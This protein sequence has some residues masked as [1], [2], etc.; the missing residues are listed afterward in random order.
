MFILEIIAGTASVRDSRSPKL[1]GWSFGLIFVI[2]FG[3]MASGRAEMFGD[4]SYATN[5]FE[6]TI[7]QYVGSG[8][9]VV[10]PE[11]IQGKPVTGIGVGAFQNCT[12]LA[13]VTIAKGVTIIGNSAFFGCARLTTAVVPDNVLFIGDAAFFNCTNLTAI[14]L[15]NGVTRIGSLAFHSCVSLK[16]ITL[17]DTV[18]NIGADA[19]FGCSGLGSITIPDSIKSIEAETFAYCSGLTNVTLPN[20]VT[21]IGSGAFE[22]C[23]GLTNICIP[24]SVLAIGDWAFS[25][26]TG[27][28][29]VTIGKSIRQL[30]V[31]AFSYCSKLVSVFFEGNAPTTVSSGLFSSA[32]QVTVYHLIGAT[33]WEPVFA[34]R[35]TAFFGPT[36]LEWAQA[37]GLL[38]RFPEASAEGD[39]PDHDG[40]SNLAEMQAG[41]D[42]MDPKSVLRF[43]NGARPEDLVDGDKTAVGPGQFV[44][45]LE[46]VPGK[47]YN[48]QSVRHLGG[49]WQTETNI[50]A[51]TTQKRV[52]LNKTADRACF[53]AVLSP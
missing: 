47:Q 5:D 4:Y 2:L 52:V 40:M 38:D 10:I 49:A 34:G 28:K 24:D 3:V 37:N 27:L 26:C 48:I 6:V 16:N 41:S 42:P 18:T 19:F 15:S 21:N 44:V 46:T 29:S 25:R 20:S 36:Y 12:N 17:P 35:P 53:R 30:G 7:T 8:G 50:T 45:Y 23:S 9:D 43:E 13:N 39:D 11:V 1:P 51:T 32:N 31:W 14:N 33:G 22:S